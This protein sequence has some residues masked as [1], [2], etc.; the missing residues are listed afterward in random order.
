M[1]I[2]NEQHNRKI[3]PVKGSASSNITSTRLSGFRTGNVF[4]PKSNPLPGPP[5]TLKL[6]WG[7]VSHPPVNETVPRRRQNPVFKP[8]TGKVVGPLAGRH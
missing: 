3:K 1:R 8:I 4:D 2:P 6:G 7:P 5:Q